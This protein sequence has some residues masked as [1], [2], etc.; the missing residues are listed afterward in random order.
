MEKLEILLLK[1]TL[2]IIPN[3]WKVDEYAHLN[4]SD[5]MKSL[6]LH[7]F[8]NTWKQKGMKERVCTIGANDYFNKWTSQEFMVIEDTP[9]MDIN[10]C[11]NK[12]LVNGSSISGKITGIPL[13][14]GNHQLLF[15]NKK[16]IDKKPES[17]FDLLEISTSVKKSKKLDYGF[18]FP[19]GACYFILPLLY[20]F[21]AGL[22]SDE[23]IPIPWDALFKTICFLKE[24]IYEK[25][26]LPIK[27]EQA[28]SIESF[29]GGRSAYCIGGD[30]NIRDFDEATDHNLGICQIPEL[31]RECR[32][33]AN[34]SYLFVSKY[35][36]TDLFDN[37][38]GFCEKMLSQEIQAKIVKEL[39]RMPAAKGFKL[40]EIEFGNLQIESY[41]VYNKAFILPPKKEVTHM[42]HVLADLLE[43]NVLVSDTP[44]KLTDKVIMLLND[45]ESYYKNNL[46]KLEKGENQ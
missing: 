17:M 16:L 43:P 14:G 46:I 32:S 39:Y 23:E 15:Y 34:A 22:W 3:S 20:G 12:Q 6:Y 8:P 24:A 33:T 37:V 7:D 30:W 44:E 40:N 29:M 10:S 1:E 41:S 28:E 11:A 5:V 26:I 4:Y 19:T 21:G 25:N 9:L 13:A 27:W 45:A 38:K 36:R 2:G 42:Y 18:V 35:L 31:E